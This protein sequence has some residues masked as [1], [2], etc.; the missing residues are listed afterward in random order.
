MGKSKE[1]STAGTEARKALDVQIAFVLSHA[2][3]SA[4][5]KDALRVA[6]DRSAIEVLNDLEILNLILRKRAALLFAESQHAAQPEE[7]T[8]LQDR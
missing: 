3:T 7:T 5:L 6:L 2:G 4:W 1:E 8:S